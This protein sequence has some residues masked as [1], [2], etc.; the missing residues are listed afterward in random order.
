MRERSAVRHRKSQQSSGAAGVFIEEISCDFKQHRGFA[1]R[2]TLTDLTR[3]LAVIAD[4]N[5]RAM[6]QL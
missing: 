1:A 5:R 4:C 2:L 3:I 6:P